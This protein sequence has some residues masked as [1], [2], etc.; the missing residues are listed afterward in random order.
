MIRQN[1][2]SMIHRLTPYAPRPKPYRTC[3]AA[4]TTHPYSPTA[5]Q[6]RQRLDE[7][8]PE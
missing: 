6:T 4:P 5:R 8:N 1:P 2:R 7:A 3:R